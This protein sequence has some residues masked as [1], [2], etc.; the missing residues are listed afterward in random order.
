MLHY[1]SKKQ[2]IAI[3]YYLKLAWIQQFYTRKK[4]SN[5]F[6]FFFPKLISHNAGH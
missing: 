2:I 3:I 5:F 4:K 1:L 6:F